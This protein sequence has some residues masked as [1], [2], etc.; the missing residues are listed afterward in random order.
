MCFLMSIASYIFS[1][2]SSSSY[3]QHITFFS[4]TE[5]SNSPG[6]PLQS[7]FLYQGKWSQKID[8]IITKTLVRLKKEYDCEGSVFP[9]HFIFEVQSLVEYHVGVT[10][11]WWE[12]V[13]RI[14]FLAR[15]YRTFCE[16]IHIEGTCWNE[17]TNGM[18][19]S[20]NTWAIHLPVC[21]MQ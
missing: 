14:H 4:T 2:S 16:L 21:S 9:S 10:F 13:D 7:C 19:V 6:F 11:E 8:S 20:S 3:I 17:A 12:L 1:P 5:M 18:T 15:R